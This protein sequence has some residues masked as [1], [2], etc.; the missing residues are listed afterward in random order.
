MDTDFYNFDKTGFIMGIIRPGIVVTRSDQVGKLKAIQPSNREQA[1]MIYSI[2]SDGFIIP[3]FLV[4]KGRF[5]LVSWYSKYQIPNDQAIKI[6]PN[7]WTDNTTSLDQLQYFDKYTKGRQIGSYQILVLN[8]YK[9]YVNAEFEKYYKENNIITIYLPPYSSYLTQPLNVGYFNVLK[10]MYGAKIKYFIKARITYIIKSKFFLTFR[11]AFYRTFSKE[12]VL[13][14]FRGS[15]LIPYDLQA[16]L[17]KLD[18]KLRT[19][20]PSKTYNKPLIPQVSKTPITTNEALSQLTL[21][22]GRIVR[23]QGSSLILIL[24]VID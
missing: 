12:N 17:S 21:I 1:T 7:G 8:S 6:I 23:Y 22:K 9:S 15:G 11:A 2:V 20:I 4:V 3:P 24:A 16:I 18:I 10:K 14:G 5:Y 13:R 19:L